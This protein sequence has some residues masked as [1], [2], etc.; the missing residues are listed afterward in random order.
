MK[1]LLSVYLEQGPKLPA[2]LDN[3]F[4]VRSRTISPGPKLRLRQCYSSKVPTCADTLN[5]SRT[6][7]CVCV[8]VKSKWGVR[9]PT[10]QIATFY[11]PRSSGFLPSPMGD[12]SLK[13]L[14]EKKNQGPSIL[15]Y[16]YMWSLQFLVQ[17]STP[18]T[19][20]AF[21][22][23]P[24]FHDIITYIDIRC[25]WPTHIQVSTPVPCLLLAKTHCQK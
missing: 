5:W 13:D 20:R 18:P 15:T 17:D 7:A 4:P 8:Y 16:W 9:V 23:F 19:R 6:N 1:T 3:I 11:M 10:T 14:E 12:N 24:I 22:L 21:L 2:M 25:C